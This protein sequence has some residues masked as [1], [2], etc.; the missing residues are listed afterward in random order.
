M[1]N[2]PV[3]RKRW[4]SYANCFFLFWNIKM[5]PVITILQPKWA[6]GSGLLLCQW[7]TFAPFS[8]HFI[9]VISYPKSLLPW[10]IPQFLTFDHCFILQ[11]W[12]SL[13][14]SCLNPVAQ[15]SEGVYRLAT[16]QRRSSF[17]IKSLKNQGQHIL[18]L[19]W[20]AK[21]KEKEM[22]SNLYNLEKIIK[23]GRQNYY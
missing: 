16:V 17:V 14:R 12:F 15:Y 4:K 10:K 20:K 23:I 19:T 3:Q 18:K 21:S 5:W 7:V 9:T 8:S 11:S 1:P 22:T 13:C 6:S 2:Q